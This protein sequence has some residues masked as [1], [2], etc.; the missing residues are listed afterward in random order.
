MFSES[1]KSVLDRH[2]DVMA[3]KCV[4]GVR[5][6]EFRMRVWRG[7]VLAAEAKKAG[8]ASEVALLMPRPPILMGNDACFHWRSFKLLLLLLLFLYGM[9]AIS[10]TNSELNSLEYTYSSAI[11]KIFKICHSSVASVLQFMHENT[12]KDCWFSRRLRFM[13]K[14]RSHDNEVVRFLCLFSDTISG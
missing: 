14:C 2:S 12:I 6:R 7:R 9:E 8:S 5:L 3:S 1:L 11:C 10:P 13:H 4:S